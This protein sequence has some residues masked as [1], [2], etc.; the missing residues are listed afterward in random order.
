MTRTLLAT[1]LAAALH[2]AVPA[3]H[4]DTLKMECNVSGPWKPFCEHVRSRFEAET[5]HKLEF[6]EMPLASDEKLSL[7]Q[8]IFAAKDARA[9]DVLFIDVIWVGLLDKHLLDLTDKVS[10]LEPAFFPNNWQNNVVNGRV[11]AVPGQVDAGMLYYRKDLLEKYREAPPTTW[12]EL[13]RIATT[14]QEAEREG[15]QKHFWGFVFQGKAYEGLSCD[16]LEWIASYNGGTVVDAQGGITVNNPKAARALDTAAKWVG[17][18]APKGVMGY[19]EEESRAVFQNGDALFMRNWPYAYLLTQNETSP[20]KGKVGVA[21]IPRGGPDGQHAATLGGWQWGVSAYSKNPDAAVTLV[22]ILAE[23]DTQ[24]RAFMLL[25]I[26]PARIESYEDPEVQAKA[27][28][29]AQFKDVFANAVPRPATA[30]RA[31]FPK[32][33]K[34][35]FNAGY[36]VL[37]GRTTGAQAVADLEGKLKRIKG[38]DWK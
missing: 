29:L 35:M 9:V 31:Q 4:A 11:K 2:A 21:P 12:E 28:Y 8:Q 32:V 23:A 20:V 38:R 14:I 27:P 19:Q 7:Y 1:G 25:G 5:P 26:P 33:S 22:R 30:T 3:A 24:K 17:T 15:G 10:D 18:I 34:A 36:D 16:V 37:S 13:T 6:I